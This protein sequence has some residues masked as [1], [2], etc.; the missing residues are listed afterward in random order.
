M[1]EDPLY[2]INEPNYNYINML[3]VYLGKEMMRA[4][5]PDYIFNKYVDKQKEFCTKLN[6]IPTRCVYF[7]L[8]KNDAFPEYSRGRETNRLCFSRI[9]DGRMSF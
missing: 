9:W 1:F 6:L 4:F 5:Q 7:G 3:S 8:D 2:V